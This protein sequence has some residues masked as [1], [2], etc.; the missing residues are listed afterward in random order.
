MHRNDKQEGEETKKKMEDAVTRNKQAE[1]VKE[2]ITFVPDQHESYSKRLR[3][4]I[5]LT[6]PV[7]SKQWHPFQTRRLSWVRA[8]TE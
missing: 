6:L 4:D 8:R 5:A 1:K 3:C 2:T 7:G